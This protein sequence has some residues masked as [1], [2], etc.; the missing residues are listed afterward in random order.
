M[1]LMRLMLCLPVWTSLLLLLPPPSRPTQ[2]H[3]L[4]RRRASFLVIPSPTHRHCGIG[5]FNGNYNLLPSEEH[6]GRQPL[7]MSGYKYP[8]FS[9]AYYPKNRKRRASST[10]LQPTAITAITCCGVVCLPHEL[11]HLLAHLARPTSSLPSNN[12][13]PPPS[14]S[15]LLGP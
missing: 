12:V 11:L 4:P 6:F 8:Q 1:W 13:S 7:V 15:S 14:T 9:H 5:E 2:Y 10:V 3:H